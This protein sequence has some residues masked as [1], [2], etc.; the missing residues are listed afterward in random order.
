MPFWTRNKVEEKAAVL[1]TSESLGSFLVLGDLGSAATP[2]AALSLYEKSTAV[3]VPI[4]IIANSFS[5][6]KPI[7]VADGIKITEHPLLDLLRHPSSDFTGCLFFEIMAKDFLIT[8]ETEIVAIGQ[9][10]RPPIQLEP[11]SPKNI[12]VTEG[13]G[14]LVNSFTISGNHLSG[15]Y[16]ADRSST[17]V[18]YISGPVRELKQIRNYSTKNDSLLRGQSP[19]VSA[20]REAKQHILGGDHNVALLQNGAKATLVYNLEEDLGPVDFKEAKEVILKAHAGAKNA[21][22]IIVVAGGKATVSE[23]GNSNRDMDFNKLQTAAKQSVALQYQV[24]LPLISIEAT[25]FN[26]Y[27]EA[28]LALYDDATIPLADK[29]FGGLEDFLFPRYKLD[30]S[31]IRLTYDPDEITALTMRRT[32]ELIKRASLGVELVNE[33][34]KSLG[35]DP[36][37][38]GGDVLVKTNRPNT[39]PSSRDEE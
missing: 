23:L 24:P 20:S 13:A 7:L 1:G 18:R 26:N 12:S 36:L 16:K 37:P 31:K 14:G 8:G 28:K 21:G 15:N 5:S 34:R 17:E 19:L 10:E 27:R 30:S 4:N 6:L 3:S 38:D 22:S 29:L 11:V 32:S 35:K 2:A 9:T 33:I 39:N 25:S